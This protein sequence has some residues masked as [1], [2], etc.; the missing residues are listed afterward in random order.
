MRDLLNPEKALI[1]R[2][3]HRDNI[4]WL[5]ANGLHCR[6]SERSDPN[7]VTIGNPSLIDDRRYHPVPVP[8]GGYLSDYVPFYFTP[9]SMMA[10]NINTGFRGIQKRKNEEIVI[11]VSSLPKLRND[12]IPFLFSDR[13]AYVEYVEFCDD[14]SRLDQIAWGILQTKDF[15]KDPEDPEKTDRYQAE[16][17]VHKYLP[18]SSLL[19]IAC[20]NTAVRDS[21]VALVEN[22]GLSLRVIRQPGWYFR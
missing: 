4:P 19:G 8:P 17:L 10:F 20:Y 22:A 6:N 13:H 14:L 9:F 21:T 15:K 7:F 11:L 2:I 5:L 16:A 1:F 3:T 12:G 18:I